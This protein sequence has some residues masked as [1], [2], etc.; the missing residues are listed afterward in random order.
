MLYNHIGSIFLGGN[1]YRIIDANLNRTVEALRV[2]EEIARFK[3]NDFVLSTKLK[4]IR[5]DICMFFDAEYNN[6]LNSR[7]TINDIGTKMENIT[8]ASRDNITI[9]SIF[10]S[11][12]KRLEQA[13]RVLSEYSNLSDDYRY[14]V[15]TIEKE[16]NEKLNMDL[17]KYL[18]KDKKLYLVTNSDNF[19]SD[20]E[21]LDTVALAVKSGVDIVQLREK[22][23]PAAKI[24]K[25][26]KI[27]RQLT[28]EYGALFIVNDRVDLAQ[29]LNADG[30][31]LGQDDIDIHDAREILGQE[32]IIGISTHR[33]QDAHDAIKN[34]ADYIGVGPVFKTPT[35]PNREPAGLDYLKWAA[36]N[37][38]IPFY[39]IGS[40][41]EN[42]INDVIA[43][44]A[45]RVAVVRAIMNSVDVKK[46]VTYFK[47]ILS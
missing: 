47:N 39:A 34:G 45:S 6:L 46:T 35:K 32:K 30:V 31:H 12:I 33:P 22:T 28:S 40:I 7:D 44:G 21:F 16:M 10:R 14:M 43:N 8:K 9:Q 26:G 36:E 37:V 15:Y 24:I 1:L 18:L 5:H 13:L 4:N 41:D 27:I 29:I 2:L 19:N 11:N 23:K 17:K 42:S 25:Y 38:N 20:D 3:L